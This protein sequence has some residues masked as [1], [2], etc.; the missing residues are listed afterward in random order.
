[1]ERDGGSV[2]S[3]E[4]DRRGRGEKSKEHT[5]ILEINKSSEVNGYAFLAN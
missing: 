1:M 3:S 4:I 2:G 5:Q